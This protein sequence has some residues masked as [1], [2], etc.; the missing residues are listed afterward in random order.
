MHALGNSAWVIPLSKK[1]S[2]RLIDMYHSSLDADSQ[3]RVV[4]S[5]T[6]DGVLRCVVS[7]IAFGMG[8]DVPDV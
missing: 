6:S 8:I 7:T 1:P 4:K 3:D 2:D 5:F